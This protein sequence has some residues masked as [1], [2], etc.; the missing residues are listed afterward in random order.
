[1]ESGAEDGG[2]LFEKKKESCEDLLA[3]GCCSTVGDELKTG[4]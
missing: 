3:V 2:F 4:R 1:M